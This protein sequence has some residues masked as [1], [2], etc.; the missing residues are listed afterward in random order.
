[1]NEVMRVIASILGYGIVTLTCAAMASL[2]WFRCAAARALRDERAWV[3]DLR[4]KAQWFSE[5]VPTVR[6]IERLADGLDVADVRDRWRMER[7]KQGG[8]T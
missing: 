5:D 3:R 6:L 7:E 2:C 8:A 4:A 1:V